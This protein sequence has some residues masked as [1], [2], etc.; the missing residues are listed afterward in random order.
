MPIRPAAIFRR[1]MHSSS[2]VFISGHSLTIAKRPSSPFG[3][4]KS[5]A[6]T[7]VLFS[8]LEKMKRA[9]VIAS[10]SRAVR[11]NRALAPGNASKSSKSR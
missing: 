1:A 4:T 9:I 11:H 3:K 7:S 10:A 2:A 8:W 6:I 5:L